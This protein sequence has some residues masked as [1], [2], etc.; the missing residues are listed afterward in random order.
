M[1]YGEG[2]SREGSLLD[3][4]AQH[5]IVQKSGAWY[6]YGDIRL[7]QGREN[8][9]NFLKDNPELAAELEQKIRKFMDEE[10]AKAAAESEARRRQAQAATAPAGAAAPT[11]PTPGATTPRA[12]ASPAAPAA[13]TI[14]SAQRPIP[15]MDDEI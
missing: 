6:A 12:A 11:S 15:K 3:M 9:R 13:T 8:T 4:A 2:I 5:K 10:R 14:G 7:G 1:I